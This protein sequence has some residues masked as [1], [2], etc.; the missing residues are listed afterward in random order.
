MKA[1]YKIDYNLY[2]RKNPSQNPIYMGQ[3]HDV[4]RYGD[5]EARI[6]ESNTIGRMY[7]TKNPRV[8]L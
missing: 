1:K 3:Y 7:G 6:I 4:Q 8:F 5:G 2:V